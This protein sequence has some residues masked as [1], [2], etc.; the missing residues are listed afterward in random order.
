MFDMW[1]NYLDI[2]VD[3]SLHVPVRASY[4]LRICV[5]FLGM[6]PYGL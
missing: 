4:F 3:L 1:P 2:L 6:K 5:L